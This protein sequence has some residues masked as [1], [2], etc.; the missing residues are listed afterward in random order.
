MEEKEKR[1]NEIKKNKRIEEKG[2]GITYVI[3]FVDKMM[4]VE[5]SHRDHGCPSARCD[6]TR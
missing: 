5:S 6:Y 3:P 1:K 2:P 4:R